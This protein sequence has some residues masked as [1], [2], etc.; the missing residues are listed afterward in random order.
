MRITRQ[1]L[2]R[3]AKEN[4]QQRAVSNPDLLAA[5]LT[6]SLLSDDP[7][8]AG[9]TDIDLVFIHP[10][11]PP[12]RRE[13]V[14]LNREIHL[15]IKHNPR[16]EYSQPRD[17]RSHPWLG[18]EVYDPLILF[19]HEH[20]LEFV[21]AGVRDKFTEPVNVFARSRRNAEHA[22]QIW[23]GLQTGQ[24]SGPGLMLMYLRA[25][26][27]AANAIAILTGGPLPERRFL[28]QFP[29]RCEAAGLPGMSAGLVGLLGGSHADTDTLR[30]FLPE[31][32]SA[33]LDAAT[34]PKVD[35]RIHAA[36][37][38]YYKTVFDEILA[39]E[40]PVACLWALLHTWSLSAAVLP[41]TKQARWMA[42]CEHLGLAGPAFSD[43]LEGLDRFLDV[44]EEH[45][46]KKTAEYG[47]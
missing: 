43:R 13:I 31:W 39:G 7:F 19:D 1:A 26:N 10:D 36:R 34:R 23:T 32:E 6:G 44:L 40:N 45:L 38:G 42:A 33:F 25:I 12:V 17:L 24:E 11:D 22:R 21:Q 28:I 37:F 47:L 8:M 14:P 41:A 3:I 46:D 2:I 18:P 29:S 16:S 30:A 27:H 4:A 15:D 35:S 9:T 5:Y 20:F